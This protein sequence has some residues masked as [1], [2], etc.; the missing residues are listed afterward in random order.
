MIRAFL[1]MMLIGQGAQALSCML[2]D[3]STKFHDLS[4]AQSVFLVVHGAVTFDERALPKTDHSTLKRK[5]KDIPATIKGH[6]L[7]PAGYVSKFERDI[8]LQVDC[9]GPWCPNPK[10]GEPYL[11]F[12]KKTAQALTLELD[13]CGGNGFANPTAAQLDQGLACMRGEVCIPNF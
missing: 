4:T 10:S 12:L 13:A 9:L 5:T 11:A 7:T 6:L 2:P 8:V 3:V 1:M